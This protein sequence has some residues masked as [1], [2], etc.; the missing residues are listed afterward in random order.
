SLFGAENA[1]KILWATEPMMSIKALIVA[2]IGWQILKHR[3]FA[4]QAALW[5]ILSYAILRSL[6]E[7]LRGDTVRGVWFG[8]AVSTSQLISMVVALVA[9][10]LLIKNR[11]TRNFLPDTHVTYE[12][13]GV[14]GVQPA[15]GKSAASSKSK[16]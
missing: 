12:H 9:I 7:M 5:M 2:F 10:A 4:G 16:S 14:G 3:R 8:G 15:A 13:A 6:V 1:G 11:N